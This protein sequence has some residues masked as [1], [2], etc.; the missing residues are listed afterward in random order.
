VHQSSFFNGSVGI[1]TTIPLKQLHVQTG[2]VFINGNVGVGTT[3]PQ[4]KLHVRGNINFDGDIFQ[5][6]AKY[7]SSQWSSAMVGG[8]PSIYI[9]SNVGIGTTLPQ[10]GLHVCYQANFASNVT[11]DS[12]VTVNGLLSTRGNIASISDQKVK[13]NLEPIAN[14]LDRIGQMKGY[15]Y[16]RVDIGTRE[17]GLIAQQVRE[18]LPEVVFRVPEHDLL[19]ISYGN[20][21]GLFVEA[22]K[23]LKSQIQHLQAEVD[24]LKAKSSAS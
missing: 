14:P 15:M 11:F 13:T 16:D 4:F 12:N 9:T 6:G 18:I 8:T 20:M 1:G 22:I 3:N 21:A 5:N 2:D 10:T 23:E 17:C 7:A 19:T 24:D